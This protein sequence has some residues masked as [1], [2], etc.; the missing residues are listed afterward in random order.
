MT[1]S[2]VWQMVTE[3][4]AAKSID[5]TDGTQL[6]GVIGS[7]VAWEEGHGEL[8]SE[9]V[10]APCFAELVASYNAAHVAAPAPE[11]TPAVETA[12]TPAPETTTAPV[13]TAPTP[14]VTAT[15]EAAPVSSTT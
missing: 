2:S 4:A 6:A 5:L 11:A 9:I 10:S 8:E 3:F 12:P 15:G 1:V 13:E 14:E 7:L